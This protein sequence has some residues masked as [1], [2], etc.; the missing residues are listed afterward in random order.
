MEYVDRSTFIAT[1]CGKQDIEPP[2]LSRRLGVQLNEYRPDGWVLL[3]AHD[4]GSSWAG[5]LTILPYGPN[6]TLKEV[7][8]GPISPRG[9]ASDMSVVIQVL[10]REK[11]IESAGAEE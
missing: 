11:F 1:Y 10:T 9:L 4:F 5:Q 7:P 8:T 2:E 3:E 6:C